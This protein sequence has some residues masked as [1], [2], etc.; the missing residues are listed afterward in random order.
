M[1]VE[2]DGEAGMSVALMVIWLLAVAYTLVSLVRPLPPFRTRLRTVFLGVPALALLLIAV[3]AVGFWEQTPEERARLAEQREQA[4]K[5]ANALSGA[6]AV[7]PVGST[8]ERDKSP[9]TE[10]AEKQDKAEPEQS[11]QTKTEQTPLA[12]KAYDPQ[13][14]SEADGFTIRQLNEEQYELVGYAAQFVTAVRYCNYSYFAGDNPITA[15]VGKYGVHRFDFKNLTREMRESTLQRIKTESTWRQFCG[16]G[17]Y[18]VFGPN[19]A[20]F[21]P[22]GE[23][24][25]IEPWIRPIELRQGMTEAQVEADV[26]Y[27]VAYYGTARCVPIFSEFEPAKDQ[28]YKAEHKLDDAWYQSTQDQ[29]IALLNEAFF[30]LGPEGLMDCPAF[31]AKYKN[32]LPPK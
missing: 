16:T 21:G 26:E 13:S 4:T 30:Q 9:N 27:N 19:G 22:D 25:N 24:P 28:A 29:S 10:L 6:S 31:L 3:G 7:Q 32:V 11:A 8:A 23:Y 5:D 15:L 14:S 1:Y 20:L 12:D 18:E 2:D 17:L